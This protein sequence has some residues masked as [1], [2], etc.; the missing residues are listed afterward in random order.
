MKSP[1]QISIVC[2]PIERKLRHFYTERYNY[3]EWAEDFPI[4]RTN[5]WRAVFNTN[6][7]TEICWIH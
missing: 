6:L 2:D 3:R 5:W 4:S 7:N 1:I